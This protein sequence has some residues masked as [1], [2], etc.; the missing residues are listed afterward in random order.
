MS[1]LATRF[2]GQ[3]VIL[4][5]C[6]SD[7]P[8]TGTVVRVFLEAGEPYYEIK[9]DGQ[10]FYVATTSVTWIRAKKSIRLVESN[11]IQMKKPRVTVN[12]V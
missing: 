3:E 12:K 9:S 10:T 7:H 5:E 2:K 4:K 8:W 1:R 11:V 6:S